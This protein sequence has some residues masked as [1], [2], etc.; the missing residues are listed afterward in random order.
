MVRS[1]S[2]RPTR[3]QSSIPTILSFEVA[4][5]KIC[6]YSRSHKRVWKHWISFVI[7]IQWKHTSLPL[8][9]GIEGWH[10]DEDGYFMT[11]V[12][13]YLYRFH[14]ELTSIWYH[15]SLLQHKRWH[16]FQAS[17]MDSLET[18]TVTSIAVA[19]TLR[20]GRSKYHI[21]VWRARVQ[22]WRIENTSFYATKERS[23]R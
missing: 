18:L 3:V 12:S 22:N 7:V 4:W 16:F 19:H 23:G 17:L 1:R 5:K 20:K 2:K 14:R 21:N 9:F 10:P 15:L 8:T 13:S 6:L 11:S